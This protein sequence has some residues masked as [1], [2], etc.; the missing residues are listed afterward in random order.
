VRAVVH[1]LS[2][3]TTGVR[4]SAGAET[5]RIA[6]APVAKAIQDNFET[7][8]MNKVLEDG[9]DRKEAEDEIG[10]LQLLLS[11]IEQAELSVSYLEDGTVCFEAAVA[12][13]DGAQED[14]R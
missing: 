7:L 2:D 3:S 4:A 6:G 14:I 8:V 13:V 1:R 11:I 9:V 10:G 12:I 5:L